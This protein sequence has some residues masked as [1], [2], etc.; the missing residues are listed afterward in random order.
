MSEIF[1]NILYPIYILLLISIL[2]Y[3]F[4]YFLNLKKCPYCKE[5]INKKALICPHCRSKLN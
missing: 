2:I 1:F 5:Y 3:V 4:Y